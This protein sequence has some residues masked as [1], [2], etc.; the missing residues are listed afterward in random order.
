MVAIEPGM[1]LLTVCEKGVGKRTPIEEYRLTR[2]GG[3]GVINIK[4]TDKNGPVVALR[5]VRDT[6]DLMIITAGGIM[7]R[8]DLS[9]VRDIGRATQGVRL[10]RT[11]EGDKVVSVAILER[12]EGEEGEVPGDAEPSAQAEP[13][14][15]AAEPDEPGEPDETDETDEASSDE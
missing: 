13:E 12:E 3:K 1:S 14:D 9:R 10:I 6:D 4:I 11:D 5:P 7:L 15:S 8:T 2:R